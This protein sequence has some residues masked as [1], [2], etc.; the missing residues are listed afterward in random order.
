MNNVGE[1]KFVKWVGSLEIWLIRKNYGGLEGLLGDVRLT[2]KIYNRTK[3]FVELE[4]ESS[5]DKLERIMRSEVDSIYRF[6]WN[7][8]E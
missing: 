1:I 3:C 7:T 4:D 6:L 2:P 5:L 8:Y